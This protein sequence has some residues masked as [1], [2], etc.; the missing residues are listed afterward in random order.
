MLKQENE[1]R[2]SNLSVIT[3]LVA[4]VS[5][6]M[7][8]LFLLA[9]CHRKAGN[10]N[11]EDDTVRVEHYV[12]TEIPQM[13]TD[14]EQ[15]VSY[16]VRHYWEGYS[17]EDTAFVLGN[18]TEQ[19]Y[20]DFID[21][22][23]YVADTSVQN[24]ALRYMMELMEKDSLAYA[25]FCLLGEKY[26]Y[27][28]NSPMRNEDYYIAVL[29]Q[30]MDSYRLTE[31]EKIRPADRL[32]QACMNRPGMKASDFGY[33]TPDGKYH[34]MSG[35]RTDFTLLFFYDPDCDSCRKLE[36]ILSEMPAFVDMQKE[37]KLRVLA[38]YPDEDENEWLL[39]SSQMPQG[40][41]VGW[42]KQGD[43]R[44]RMLYEIRAT[45]TLYLLDKQK[46]VLLKDPSL[47]QLVRYLSDKK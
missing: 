7:L 43:I 8:S 30:M 12:R 18:D 27:D 41:V 9:G 23:Q 20:A 33:L 3:G 25:R 2:K 4:S 35:I 16:L 17:M 47:E 34:R 28:P 10:I 21:A 31:V 13:M 6:V 37:N 19:L 38:V 36:K 11:K 24:S 5:I 39:K 14:P 15:R 32:K 40:W 1:M 29:K 26:L 45:P 42:N 22:L 44:S 46:R